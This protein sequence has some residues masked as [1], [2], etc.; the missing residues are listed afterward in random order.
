MANVENRDRDAPMFVIYCNERRVATMFD[1]QFEDMF[2]C[3]YRLEP[4]DE[5]GDRV[6]HDVTIWE[7]V[8]FVVKDM[9]G[10]LPNS[11]TFSGGFADFCDRKT[12][13]LSF[14]SL[15]PPRPS[16]TS[17]VFAAFAGLVGCNSQTRKNTEP[18]TAR[19]SRG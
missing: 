14:R 3:S 6:I 19:G 4:I 9:Q 18:E 15:W 7:H 13:R 8:A 12:D 5:F 16:L 17:R 1:P 10:N 11:N 2:W